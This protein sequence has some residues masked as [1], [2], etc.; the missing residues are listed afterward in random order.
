[1]TYR[2]ADLFVTL[3]ATTL[4]DMKIT[5]FVGLFVG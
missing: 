4:R 5:G 2:P 3:V 1:M